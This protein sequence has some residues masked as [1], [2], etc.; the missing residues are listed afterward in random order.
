MAN[1]RERI[2]LQA[3][4]M[5]EGT[6]LYCDRFQG[7]A[8]RPDFIKLVID[9]D[10]EQVETLVPLRVGELLAGAG[11][12]SPKSGQRGPY[13]KVE[14]KPAITLEKSSQGGRDF[15]IVSVNGE[16]C[17][18][19]GNLEGGAPTSR[20]G[21]RSAPSGPRPLSNDPATVDAQLKA[22]AANYR[23]A[24]AMANKQLEPMKKAG[25]EATSQDFLVITNT[26]FIESCRR[27]LDCTAYLDSLSQSA[28]R[29]PVKQSVPLPG[30]DDEPKPRSVKRRP[31]PAPAEQQSFEDVP[32]PIAA[33]EDDL[34]F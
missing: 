24:M 7:K 1:D 6:L 32:A 20:T 14:G 31:K 2:S 19:T 3:G 12:L 18:T 23:A 15:Y 9:V 34:P 33:D 26:L 27:A 30:A 16:E 10:G 8:G 13:L 25:F 29:A 4:E 5:L 21:G 28:A 22:I 11:V 17:K